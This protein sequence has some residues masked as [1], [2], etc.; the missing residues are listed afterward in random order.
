MFLNVL[1]YYQRI[2][3]RIWHPSRPVWNIEYISWFYSLIMSTNST[4]NVFL[5]LAPVC[6]AF[7]LLKIK[8]WLTRV[9]QLRIIKI[10]PYF[11]EISSKSDVNISVLILKT[12][13]KFNLLLVNANPM[14]SIYRS[15]CK[16]YN[17]KKWAFI[18]AVLKTCCGL[19]NRTTLYAAPTR[20]FRFLIW[21]TL[22]TAIKFCA[23]L[24][25]NQSEARPSRKSMP[26]ATLR[27]TWIYVS[28]AHEAMDVY[29]L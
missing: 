17:F 25:S 12:K 8:F 6:S 20:S 3:T 21:K 10:F 14:T 15:S 27:L 16:S 29:S 18:M 26:C 13:V 2:K 19:Y 23:W 7:E 4:I 24:S 9:S 5:W 1:I 28:Y 11:F 22:E